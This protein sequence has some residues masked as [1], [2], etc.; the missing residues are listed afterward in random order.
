MSGLKNIKYGTDLIVSG[1]FPQVKELKICE[2]GIDLCI[3]ALHYHSRFPAL[4]VQRPD[5]ARSILQRQ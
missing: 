5:Q 1:A 3:R 4:D 2:L